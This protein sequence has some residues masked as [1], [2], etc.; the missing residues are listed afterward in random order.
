MDTYADT[1][2]WVFALHMI[3]IGYYIGAD[4]VVDQWT[5]FLIK[6][7]KDPVEERTRKL[8]FLLLCDQHPRMG[9]ILFIA[10]GFSVEALAGLSPL[11]AG[12]LPW[13]WLIC[14]AWFAEVWISF[15]NEHTPWGKRIVDADIAWRHLVGG[16]FLV[17]GLWSLLGDGPYAPNWMA[18]KYLLLGCLI[19]G[20]V[21]IRFFVRDLARAWPE[22]I[23]TGSTPAFEDVIHRTLFT[24][25]KVNWCLWAMFIAM[26]VLQIWRPF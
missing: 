9:L 21:S 13:L 23:K 26:A 10:T 1:Y 15:L 2:T 24:A 18:L 12:D 7:A 14:A 22:F 19:A 6:S 16:G 20:G 3:V 25:M 4:V 11:T 5:W 8:K 17:T